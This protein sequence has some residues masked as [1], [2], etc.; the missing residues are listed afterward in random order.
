MKLYIKDRLYFPQI[1][2]EKNSFLEFNM[3]KDMLSRIFIKDEEKEK[4]NIQENPENNSIT[5]DPK[6][7]KENP[8]VIEFTKQEMAYIKRGIE[9]I[10]TT[11]LPDDFWVFIERIY[12]EINDEEK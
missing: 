7:D 1:L 2:P 9:M 12:N 6:I 8:L 3:K 11:A 5:W 4:F 10:S